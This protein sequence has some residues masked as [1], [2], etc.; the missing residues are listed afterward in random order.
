[1]FTNGNTHISQESV[2]FSQGALFVFLLLV[3]LCI[4]LVSPF[5]TYYAQ[6]LHLL[7]YVYLFLGIPFGLGVCVALSLLGRYPMLN[8]LLSKSSVVLGVL[9]VLLLVVQLF[10]VSQTWFKTGWDVR[11]VTAANQGLDLHD[12]TYLAY[13]SRYPNQYFLEALNYLISRVAAVFGVSDSYLVLVVLNVCEVNLACLITALSSGK[14]LGQNIVF[15]TW[16]CMVA[17]IGLSPWIL[18][19][20]SD[21]LGMFLAALC[22]LLAVSAIRPGI[23]WTLLG[24]LTSLAVAIKPT[25]MA[26]VGA[27]VLVELMQKF[28]RFLQQ[29]TSHAPR[30]LTKPTRRT[31]QQLMLTILFVVGILV[32]KVVVGMTTSTFPIQPETRMQLGA[33]HYLMMG[34]NQQTQGGYSDADIAYSE[35]FADPSA[36]TRGD[37]NEFKFRIQQMGPVQLGKLYAKKLCSTFADGSFSWKQEGSFFIETPHAGTYFS[38]V[39]GIGDNSSARAPY[40]PISQLLWFSVLLGCIAACIMPTA[41]K[42]MIR[43]LCLSILGLG[44]FLM[45]F[46]C[47]A[48]YLIQFIP[49]FVVLTV[50][51][52]GHISERFGLKVQA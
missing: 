36:R 3:C 4:A 31:V 17:L 27:I 15:P 20:Y 51:G 46:E 28:T 16:F 25:L 9:S 41:E 29:R 33:A 8:T 21:C 10:V 11:W 32:G 43:P 45:L 35:S 1:M 38:Q 19:P 14:I 37:L 5:V 6:S 7:N 49:Y 40:T 50:A 22:L 26:L 34:H 12:P 42:S 48:R 52:W 13:V 47:R 18:V 39:Y 30:H 24:T 44:L 23:K 2:G